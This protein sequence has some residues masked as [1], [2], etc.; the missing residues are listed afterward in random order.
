MAAWIADTM[1]LA[2]IGFVGYVLCVAVD[3][4]TIGQL[5][6]L[7]T[8]LLFANKTIVDLKPVY[9]RLKAFQDDLGTV[10]GI[11]DNIGNSPILNW[12]PGTGILTDKQKWAK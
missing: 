7:V 8:V 1:L 11:K 3:R 5:I 9:E 2:I 10:Q 4:K 12:A 6:I